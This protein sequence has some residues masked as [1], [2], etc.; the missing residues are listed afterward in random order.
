MEKQK[1][2]NKLIML[3]NTSMEYQHYMAGVNPYIETFMLNAIVEGVDGY[4]ARNVDYAVMC[5]DLFNNIHG[6]VDAYDIEGRRVYHNCVPVPYYGTGSYEDAVNE[7]FENVVDMLYCPEVGGYAR[8]VVRFTADDQRLQQ[9]A[10]AYMS[11]E[12]CREAC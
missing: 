9:A 12:L 5:H 1:L 6:C 10:C 7:Y 3:P 8:V 11:M 2:L 4:M